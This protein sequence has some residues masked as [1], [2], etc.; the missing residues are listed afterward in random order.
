[1]L[2][3][4]AL[5]KEKLPAVQLDLYTHHRPDIDWTMNEAYQ[6]FDNV[7]LSPS[8][9]LSSEGLMMLHRVANKYDVIDVQYHQ[10]GQSLRGFR[11][12]GN[13]LIFTPMESR[14][15]ALWTSL[16]ELFG[17]RGKFSLKNIPPNLYYT[18]Q[19][20]SYCF[21][22]DEVVCVSNTDAEFLRAVTRSHK[23]S[24][25]ETGLS[26]FEFSAA[27]SRQEFDVAPE[28]KA[29]HIV[30]VA[31]FGSGTN[32]AA[33]RWYLDNVHPIIKSSVQDYVLDV[34]GRGDLSSFAQY[35]EASVNFVGEVA[36]LAPCL[37]RARVGIAPALGGSGFRGKV[38][39]YAILG[40]PSVVSPIALHGLVYED[41]INIFAAESPQLFAQRCIQ[42]LTDTVLN[43]RM[44]TAARKLCLGRYTWASKWET[45]CGIYNLQGAE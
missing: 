34:V 16:R 30:Y 27:L 32:Q 12:L 41:G 4:Y 36:E 14:A 40:V 19:E 35:K 5:I 8:E 2:D 37:A 38:N 3:I 28:K 22:A 9:E 39:Q 33:L 11:R 13:K 24:V 26:T 1:M 25:L 31:A 10:R 18:Y 6:I 7:Y 23:V 20:I 17:M 44:G 21:K 43:A 42:L 45:I 29:M 15:L